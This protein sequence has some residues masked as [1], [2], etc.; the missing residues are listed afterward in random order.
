[1]FFK[2]M[3][4]ETLGSRRKQLP[5]V[6]ARND[7]YWDPCIKIGTRHLP[8]TS[9]THCHGSESGPLNNSIQM[10]QVWKKLLVSQHGEMSFSSVFLITKHP[11]I[12]LTHD[13]LQVFE[14]TSCMYNAATGY[15]S[16]AGILFSS[17]KRIFLSPSTPSV[18]V[19]LNDRTDLPSSVGS[20]S[21][22]VCGVF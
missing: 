18:C 20:F 21:T 14:V 16:T 2:I 6:F 17:G 1:M 22:S 12:C 15:G 7:K 9:Q 5:K 8:N 4:T 13:V 11:L 19:V 10:I 3:N